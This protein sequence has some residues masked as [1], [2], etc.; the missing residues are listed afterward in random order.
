VTAGSAYQKAA[1]DRGR[2]RASHADRER[3]VE[4]LK[5]A[6]VQGRLTK[7]ELDARLGQA[8]ASRTYSELAAVTAD[9]PVGLVGAQLLRAPARAQA[10]ATNNAVK[11]AICLIVAAA[12]LVASYFAGG[13]EFHLC[14][15]CYFVALVIAA[16]E[17]LHVR[18]GKRSRGSVRAP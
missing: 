16:V 14:V 4:V 5:A 3:A 9:I 13:Y 10:R 2:L 15:A 6:F 17:I 11:A 7:D 8:F 1:A 18:H 12:M